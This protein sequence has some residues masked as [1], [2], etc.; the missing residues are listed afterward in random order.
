MLKFAFS[1]FNLNYKNYI[2]LNSKKYLRSVEIAKNKSNAKKCLKRNKINRTN[3]IFGEK[4]IIKLIK[5]YLKNKK[6]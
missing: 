4:I 3:K 2:I 5:Y 6:I 1:Y